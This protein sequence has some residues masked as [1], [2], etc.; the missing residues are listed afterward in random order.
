MSLPLRLEQYYFT[1]VHIEANPKFDLKRDDC[2]VSF[3][4]QCSVKLFQNIKEPNRWQVKLNL[5]S[6]NHK[7]KACPYR[8]DVLVVGFF[9]VAKEVDKLKAPY[10]VQANGSAI[11]YSALREFVL[12]VT[13]RGPWPAFAIPTTNF[14]SPPKPIHEKKA[15]TLQE[16]D[17]KETKSEWNPMVNDGG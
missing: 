11:L 4:G 13:G 9:K 6:G 14:L 1:K 8:I 17:K 12:T 16:K 2:T 5:T 7:K 3:N 10:L 15:I